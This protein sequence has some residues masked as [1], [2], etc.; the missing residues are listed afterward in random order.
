MSGEGAVRFPFYFP[1]FNFCYFLCVILFLTAIDL[2]LF[3]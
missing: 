2:L 1:H 3:K